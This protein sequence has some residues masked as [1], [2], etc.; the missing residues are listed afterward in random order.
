MPPS[1]RLGGFKILKDVAQFSLVFAG[2]KNQSPAE[3]FRVIAEGKINLPYITSINYGN[4]WGLNIIVENTHE[5]TTSHLIEEAFGNIFQHNPKSAI[6]S[7]FPHKKNP[8]ITGHLLEVFGQ[9]GLRP[10]SFANSPSAISVVLRED[11]LIQASN[12]L[13]EPFSFSAY[14]TPA[15]WKLAQKGKEQLY[16]EVVASYQEQKPKVYG[17]E[18]H[19]GQEL[20]QV[21][22]TNWDVGES[23]AAF[24]EFARLGLYLTFFATGPCLD[25]GK[26]KVVFCLPS[27][28]T[29]DL[30][31]IIS[32]TS[33]G[34]SVESTCPVTVFSMN[35]PH[36]GDRYG[37]V[38][39]LLTSFQ[40]SETDLLG[41]GCT[42]ASITG[43]VHSHQ[44]ESA[45]QAIRECF[46]VPTITK[47]D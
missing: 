38:S 37:I 39:E 14:R 41:L 47:K 12:A 18:Y 6:L 26:E 20:V 8:G 29:H 40:K 22:S 5:G 2:E 24:K 19:E 32:K 10:G 43:V 16:K 42:I 17:L 13:F 9:E 3:F 21:V 28:E 1:A 25:G 46:E 11:Q 45:I 27:S 23:G 30:G 34:V 36:F 31:D 15:D 33:P 4:S 7:I 44:L 35:G